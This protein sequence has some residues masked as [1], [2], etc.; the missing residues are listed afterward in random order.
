MELSHHCT[1]WP[2]YAIGPFIIPLSRGAQLWSSLHFIMRF[3]RFACVIQQV[4]AMQSKV[5]ERLPLIIFL[6]SIKAPEELG[7]KWHVLSLHVS[8]LHIWILI[9]IW[10]E[11]GRLGRICMSRCFCIFLPTLV[12]CSSPLPNSIS[13]VASGICLTKLMHYTPSPLNVLRQ[14]R[15]GSISDANGSS[16]LNRFHFP[17]QPAPKKAF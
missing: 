8:Y 15:R 3:F 5:E 13:A 10:L 17:P 6:R 4:F 1:Q 2:A 9:M 16:F 11:I 14:H 7:S 12:I